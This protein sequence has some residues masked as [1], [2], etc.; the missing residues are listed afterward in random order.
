MFIL[1]TGSFLGG[2]LVGGA[3]AAFVES[4]YGEAVGQQVIN[5][6]TNIRSC[7]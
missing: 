1:G 3:G 2:V 7:N 6:E 5:Y 4:A